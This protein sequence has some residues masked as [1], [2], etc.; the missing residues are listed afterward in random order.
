MKELQ[1]NQRWQNKIEKKRAKPERFDPKNI[2]RWIRQLTCWVWHFNKLKTADPD[3]SKQVMKTF[4]YFKS[5]DPK[6]LKGVP[7]NFVFL[8]RVLDSREAVLGYGF[9]DAWGSSLVLLGFS[10]FWF[11]RLPHVAFPVGWEL[12]VTQVPDSSSDIF[13]PV[14]FLNPNSWAG[15]LREN[16]WSSLGQRSGGCWTEFQT[17]QILIILSSDYLNFSPG[18]PCILF[19]C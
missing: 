6:A 16:H 10:I 19:T 18:N 17:A 1:K 7:S 2:R 11:L 15:F 9:L 8:K 5:N 3:H 12:H 13:I 14:S 4:S